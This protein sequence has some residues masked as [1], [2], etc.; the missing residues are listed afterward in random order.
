MA[1]TMLVGREFYRFG[2][3]TKEG[4]SSHVREVG[5]VALNAAGV[6]LVGS[7]ALCVLKRQTGGFFSR[8]KQVRYFTHTHYDVRME[9]VVKETDFTAK[10]Y[11]RQPPSMLPMHPKIIEDMEEKRAIARNALKTP[12]EKKREA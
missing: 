8:R 7:T 10:G 1:F 11:D 2:Y 9:K 3:L 4:P 12:L 5:A 6:L